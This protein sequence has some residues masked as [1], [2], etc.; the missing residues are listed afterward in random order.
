[1]SSLSRIIKKDKGTE[2]AQS[3]DAFLG[4]DQFIA[5]GGEQMRNRTQS[6]KIVGDAR[7][8]AE[9][10]SNEAKRQAA[11]EQQSGF[12]EGI[13]RGLE[14]IA[15]IENMLKNVVH[16]LTEFKDHYPHQL[17]PEVIRMV[18]DVS[19]KIIKDR[20][21]KDKDIVIRTVQAA[22]KELTDRE[23]IKVRVHSEDYQHLNKYKPQLLESFH[24]I[25]KFDLVID[26]AVDRGGCIIETNEGTI[27]ATIKNQMKKLHGLISCEAVASQMHVL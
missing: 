10:I 21:S 11:C 3:F 14:T 20:L 7:A 25:N 6:K 4:D 9:H 22:F 15:P 27:D 13:R 2:R 23:Y 5:A 16:E 12:E 18:L 8:E 17:E 24:E 26:E 19:T 1:M